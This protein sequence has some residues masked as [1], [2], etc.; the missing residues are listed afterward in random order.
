MNTTSFYLFAV[1]NTL[2]GA[3]SAFDP[4]D[5]MATYNES[6]TGADADAI[7]AL[8]DWVAV[9]SDWSQVVRSEVAGV[10]REETLAH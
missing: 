3:A 4:A 10:Q 2:S 6:P 9:A 1:P 8:A 7:A 5:S